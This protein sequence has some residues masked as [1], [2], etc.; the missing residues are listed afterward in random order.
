MEDIVMVAG[1]AI[2]SFVVGVGTIV[3]G[4]IKGWWHGKTP[5]AQK[6]FIKIVIKAA[7]DGK[8]SEEE[9]DEVL[10]EI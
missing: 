5:E 1:T 6:R 7:A 8:I 2:V 10:S 9:R 4:T 3:L